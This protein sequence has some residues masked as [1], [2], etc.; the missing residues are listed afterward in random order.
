MRI[1]MSLDF[2]AAPAPFA[3]AVAPSAT[4]MTSGMSS[5][6]PSSGQADLTNNKGFATALADL[7]GA[8]ATPT[9]ANGFF[10]I[11]EKPGALGAASDANTKLLFEQGSSFNPRYAISQNIAPS[12]EKN[13]LA[14][15]TQGE[16]AASQGVDPSLPNAVISFLS[17][18]PASTTIGDKV[19]QQDTSDTALLD[20]P[21]QQGA[22]DGSTHVEPASPILVFL[23]PAPPPGPALNPTQSSA[24]GITTT[25]NIAGAPELPEQPISLSPVPEAQ[26]GRIL[27]ALTTDTDALKKA[28]F[29][30]NLQNTQTPFGSNAA[31]QGAPITASLITPTPATSAKT[32]PA[33]QPSALDTLAHAADAVQTLQASQAPL[34][35]ETTGSSP[36]GI[37]E[38]ARADTLALPDQAS[39]DQALAASA[40]AEAPK[41]QLPENAI[42][43]QPASQPLPAHSPLDAATPTEPSAERIKDAAPGLA[44][45][46]ENAAQTDKQADKTTTSAPPAAPNPALAQ[47]AG[48]QRFEGLLSASLDQGSPA[49]AASGP[50]APSTLLANA[51][52]PGAMS[53]QLSQSP[54]P[55]HHDLSPQ[56][57]T[58]R[59]ATGLDV[60][61][62]VG[63]HVSRLAQ[64]GKTDFIIRLD[65]AELGRIDIKL[66][67]GHDGRI[68]ATLAADS[69]PVVD[70]LRR[71]QAS[72]ERALSDA[73]LKTDQG[74]LS[75]NLRQQSDPQGQRQEGQGQSRAEGRFAQRSEGENTPTLQPITSPARWLRAAGGVELLV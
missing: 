18:K 11:G 51:T 46:T 16:G 55:I 30:E 45:T 75:F 60:A 25:P 3:P 65:P 58:V 10:S 37:V 1:V 20:E 7:L 54:A 48:P 2:F 19:V 5:A 52:T 4:A 23:Q 56:H 36:A 72:L 61:A 31:A 42:P 14:P 8:G 17:Q 9:K 44:K 39:P 43:E 28:G 64:E 67:V 70:L 24:V 12:V 21:V 22:E 32:T 34:I 62:Q 15:G 50:L 40:Q 69:A 53:T 68:Q 38:L 33:Q 63:L 71:D 13:A 29:G 74:S 47:S 49:P 35:E 6:V 26:H 66:E 73:G 41:A 27:P 57:P 59:F